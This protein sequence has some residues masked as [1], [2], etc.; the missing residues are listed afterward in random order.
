MMLAGSNERIAAALSST[1]W[2][3]EHGANKIGAIKLG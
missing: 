1:M 3:C 2:F